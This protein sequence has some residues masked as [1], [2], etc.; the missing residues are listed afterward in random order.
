MS[1]LSSH[2]IDCG[3]TIGYGRSRP[4]SV[5]KTLAL[6]DRGK[7]RFISLPHKFMDK[8][9][10]KVLWSD[11]GPKWHVVIDESGIGTCCPKHSA[12][13]KFEMGENFY[14][15][16]RIPI[17]V[18]WAL[19][20]DLEYC[21]HLVNGNIVIEPKELPEFPDCIYVY[22]SDRGP[23]T[24]VIAVHRMDDDEPKY[25][26]AVFDGD[27]REA[28][29]MYFEEDELDQFVSSLQEAQDTLARESE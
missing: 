26:T 27:D 10:T 22:E 23:Y 28:P 16:R 19:I 6:T 9:A 15:L 13:I 21:Q 1:L 2:T 25:C 20:S 18:L 17:N 5:W 4:E 14:R 8:E 3:F 29:V 11:K 7:H 24:V 12:L